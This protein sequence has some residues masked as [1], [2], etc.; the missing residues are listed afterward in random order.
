MVV[1]TLPVWSAKNPLPSSTQEQVDI[2][3]HNLCINTYIHTCSLGNK[4][5]MGQFA[6]SRLSGTLSGIRGVRKPLRTQLLPPARELHR[7]RCLMNQPSKTWVVEPGIQLTLPATIMEGFHGQWLVWKHHFPL[8]TGRNA[9]SMFIAGK[10]KPFGC[11]V[12]GG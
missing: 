1:I 7:C 11:S 10:A 9:M 12:F 4:N 3:L 5:R 8:Q 6:L 2:H